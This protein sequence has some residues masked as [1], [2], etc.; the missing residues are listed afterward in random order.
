MYKRQYSNTSLVIKA[1]EDAA[2]RDVQKI[3]QNRWVRGNVTG[4]VT[5]G[6]GLARRLRLTVRSA[7]RHDL[8]ELG[9]SCR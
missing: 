7:K 5:I 2:D 6:A 4:P 9:F 1:K 8:R 3:L